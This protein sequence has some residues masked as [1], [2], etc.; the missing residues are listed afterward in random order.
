MLNEAHDLR[1]RGIDV[2]VGFIETHGRAETEAQSAT[3]RSCRASKIEYRG[4]TLEEM[5]VDAV[6]ARRPAGRDRRRARA[7]QRARLEAPQAL[8]GRAGA[9]RRGHQ[10]H[11][12]R[13][14]PAPRVAQRRHPA[15]LGVTVRE[16]VPDWVVASGR[17][18]RQ[19]RHLRRGP[20]AA[21]RGREDLRAGEDSSRRSRTSSPPRTSRRCASWRC[22]RSRARSTA[23]ARRSCAARKPAAAVPPRTVD[24]DPRRD[25]ERPAVHGDAAA[26]GEPHRRPAQLR[27]V[28]RL[29][30]D[31]GRARRPDRR[32][33]AA[34]ARR[35][36]PDGAVAWAP[37][38]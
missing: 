16:T 14:R 22:A 9:A 6:I 15:T 34:T 30:A 2:V 8:G 20:A 32:H 24:R 29:R 13:E 18:G 36:H 4:V 38:S 3:S 26:Q 33:R 11:L 7:H 35:Q 21:A 27:L 25:V 17:P 37:R 10:R 5:D 31:A 28:L 19:P 23:C 1:R 12:R